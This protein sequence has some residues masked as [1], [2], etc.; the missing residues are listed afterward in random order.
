MAAAGYNPVNMN[1]INADYERQRSGIYGDYAAKLRAS[2]YSRGLAQQRG[3]RNITATIKSW[4]AKLNPLQ[5]GYARR[6][7]LDSGTYNNALTDY[8]KNSYT[9]ENDARQALAQGLRQFDLND[10]GLLSTRDSAV[11]TAMADKDR[12]IQD[13]AAQ[14][15]A[16]QLYGGL[17]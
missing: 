17:K 14:L 15:S 11:A 4:Q 6:N 8:T 13:A 16:M 5:S 12:R 10:A 2:Q 7:W 3:D 9:A 1:N